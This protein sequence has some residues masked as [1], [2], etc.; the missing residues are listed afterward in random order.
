[1]SKL[2]MI[3]EEL[4]NAILAYLTQRPWRE[5]DA[6]IVG[7]RQI[8]PL[9]ESPAEPPVANRNTKPLETIIQPLSE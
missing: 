4:A 7:L 5:V 2:Y 6:L 3:S 9:P 8:E 1:M